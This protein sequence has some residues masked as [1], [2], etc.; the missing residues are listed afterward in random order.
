MTTDTAKSA[1]TAG[2][3]AR[4]GRSFAG[5]LRPWLMLALVCAVFSVHP[6]FRGT[7]WRESYLP[8]ILQQS[9]RNIVLAVGMSFVIITG[10]IDLSVGSV[11]ALSGAGLA[12]AMN[13]PLPLWLTS[14]VALPIALLAAWRAYS[15]ARTRS[16]QTALS[17]TVFLVAEAGLTFVLSRGLAGGV[18]MEGAIAIALLIG[19]AC[20]M[21][22]GLMVS[23][24]RI[25]AFVMT[26]GMM[27]AAR[28]LTLYA[29]DS[30]S[31]PA[32]VQRFLALGQGAPL[33]TI[34]LVVVIAAAVLLARTRAGRYV[35]SIGGSEQ[36]TRLS[37]VD[38][39]AY[40][41][42]AYALSGLGAGIGAVLVTAKF[43]T[44]NTGA[45]TGAELD[46]IAAV[47]IGGTS[48]SGG[49]GSIVGALVGALTI[50]V[51]EA[52]LVLCGV[53]DTLQAVILGGVIVLTV[54]IDQVRKARQ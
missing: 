22:N 48:L 14:V 44:A 11:L 24:G 33:I 34:T 28:G 35:M 4:Q 18:K 38:V 26:L 12:L 42:M 3:F 46:A 25:P 45:G 39:A 20:G 40:K 21:A 43:G 50:T 49:Q 54:L 53:R 51:I 37:G 36:A 13:G 2:R 8:N 17:A 6:G 16:K 1:A 19:L 7:F 9:A 27:S 31:V 23:V 52:G 30:S 41:T 47:V 15:R 10:G 32:R 5:A 29:T